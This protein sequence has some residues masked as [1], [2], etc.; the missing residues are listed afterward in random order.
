MPTIVDS[1]GLTFNQRFSFSVFGALLLSEYYAR[2]TAPLKS[3]NIT[4]IEGISLSGFQVFAIHS[5]NTRAI[6][7]PNPS[8]PATCLG[9]FACGNCEANNIGVCSVSIQT[10]TLDFLIASVAIDDAPFCGG[11]IY[12][13]G[14]QPPPGFTN[15]ASQDDRFEVDYTVTTSPQA[16]VVFSCYGTDVAT[17]VVDAISFHGAFGT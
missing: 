17:M 2:A 14:Y 3:D 4:I 8:I 12:T 15:I 10:S 16:N 7:D 1:S 11:N 9:F 13:P 6:F 5:A